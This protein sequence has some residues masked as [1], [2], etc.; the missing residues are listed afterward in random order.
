MAT[1]DGPRT[2]PASGGPAKQLVIFAHGYGSNG[3]DLIG[4][5]PYLAQALPDAA[6]VSPNAP[7]Q[8]PGYRGGYQ[9]F[10]LTGMDMPLLTQGAKT[11]APSL[12][13]FID[14]ELARCALPAS[15]CALV[16]FSQGCMMSLH[17][18]LRRIEPLGAIVGLSGLLPAP[19]ALAAE[20]ASRPPLLLC[21]GDRDDRVPPQGLFMALDALAQA[22]A[23]ALWRLVGGAGHTIPEEALSLTAEFL[24]DAFAGRFAGW[25]GPVAR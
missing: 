14:A 16:G 19:E 12:H 17:V 23:P 3:E 6:F 7:Q 11:A 8:V 10:P 24:H 13:G 21:H 2:A 18:G 15:A 22:G 5:A 9:W 1:L 25:T 4:L 20:I